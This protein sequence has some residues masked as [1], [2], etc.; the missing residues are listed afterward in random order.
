M[1]E[2]YL[3]NHGWHILS[4]RRSGS[5]CLWELQWNWIINVLNVMTGSL[6]LL[7]RTPDV[8][9]TPIQTQRRGVLNVGTKALRP[10]TI[11]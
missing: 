10:G 3:R 5:G 7:L 6:D 4:I 2:M 11:T 9:T 1:K 8:I